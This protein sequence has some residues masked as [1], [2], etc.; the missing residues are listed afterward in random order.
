MKETLKHELL[1]KKN[2]TRSTFEKDNQI[3]LHFHQH[4]WLL[5]NEN[6]S[7]SETTNIHNI[8]KLRLKGP[9]PPCRNKPYCI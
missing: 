3:L 2:N 8:I 4:W 7:P 9:P 1:Q 5:E 6:N